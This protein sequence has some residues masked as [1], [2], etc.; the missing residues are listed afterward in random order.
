MS[1]AVKVL[2]K[3]LGRARAALYSVRMTLVEARTS[4]TN[5]AEFFHVDESIQEISKALN[6]TAIDEPVDYEALAHETANSARKRKRDAFQGKY[7]AFVKCGAPGC[8][9]YL[10][11]AHHGSI[12][13]CPVHAEDHEIVS[14]YAIPPHAEMTIDEAR[15]HITSLD[16]AL[17]A[18][19]LAAEDE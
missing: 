1:D 15:A 6:E 11:P 13:G 7:G 18:S 3:K 8:G 9:R 12:T 10:G 4:G 16:P 5:D 17:V 2:F 14:G 19:F